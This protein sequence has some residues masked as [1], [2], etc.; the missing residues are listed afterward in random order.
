MNTSIKRRLYVYGPWILV[1]LL[2][3]LMTGCRDQSSEADMTTLDPETIAAIHDMKVFFGH[4]SVGGNILEGLLELGLGNQDIRKSDA[5]VADSVSVSSFRHAYVGRNRH[6]DEKIADFVEI[7]NGGMAESVDAAF[8]KFCY[9]DTGHE[10]TAQQIFEQ[11][12]REME[13]LERRYPDTTIVYLTMPLTAPR[14]GLEPFIKRILGKEFYGREDNIE[15]NEFNDLLREVKKDTGRL[16]DIAAIES[17]RPDGAFQE[18]TYDGKTYRAL[19]PAYTYDGG[20]L[21]ELGRKIVAER[22]VEFLAQL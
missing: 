17:T 16:F 1:L 4:Q 15:R 14:R 9:V 3:A 10:F 22:L 19:V 20:H 21:N 18:F 8:L 13:N 6:P 7:M 11:Y 5:L 12:I 2:A